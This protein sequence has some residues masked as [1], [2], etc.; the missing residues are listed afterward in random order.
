MRAFNI[1]LK[2]KLVFMKAARLLKTNNRTVNHF[3]NEN[4]KRNEKKHDIDTKCIS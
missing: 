4:N 2:I 1:K 3:R